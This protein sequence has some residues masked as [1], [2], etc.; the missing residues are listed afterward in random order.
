[1]NKQTKFTIDKRRAWEFFYAELSGE[2]ERA[3]AI[4]GA[5]MLDDV[6]DSLVVRLSENNKSGRKMD[7]AYELNLITESERRDLIAI[8]SVRNIFAH[9]L[10]T[11]SFND[12]R[13]R[14]ICDGLEISKRFAVSANPTA[15]EYFQTAVGILIYILTNRNSVVTNEVKSARELLIEQSGGSISSGFYDRLNIL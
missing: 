13:V 5:L 6:L 15:R 2:S 4:I 12:Q 3:V 7:I 14:E 9:E 10:F 8:T 11:L 1:M